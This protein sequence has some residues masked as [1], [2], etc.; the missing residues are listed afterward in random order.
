MAAMNDIQAVVD[1]IAQVYDPDRVV[2]FG[3]HARTARRGVMPRAVH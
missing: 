1:R 3:S 2:L